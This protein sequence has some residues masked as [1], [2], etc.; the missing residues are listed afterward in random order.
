MSETSYQMLGVKSSQ[1]AKMIVCCCKD[2]PGK[3]SYHKDQL[4]SQTYL[5]WS[6]QCL[7]PAWSVPYNETKVNCQLHLYNFALD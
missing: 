2:R 3:L 7:T 4:Q 6:I 1:V 5:K